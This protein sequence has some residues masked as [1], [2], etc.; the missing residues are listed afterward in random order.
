MGKTDMT[1]S[2]IFLSSSGAQLSLLWT[3][4]FGALEV[5]KMVQLDTDK[6][7]F[8]SSVVVKN[9]GEATIRDFYCELQ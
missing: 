2:Q 7:Y 4:Q 9:V 3:A 5:K 1:P 6:L 8:T